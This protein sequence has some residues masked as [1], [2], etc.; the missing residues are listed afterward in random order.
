VIETLSSESS[1][2]T[3]SAPIAYFYCVRNSSEPERADPDEIMRC[4][5]KQLASSK[6]DLPVREPVAKRYKQLKEEAD[7]DGNE[8]PLKLTV[9]ESVELILALLERNPATIIIDALDECDPVRRHELLAALD[10]IIRDSAN[11]VKIFVS[12]RD[13]HDILCRLGNS[14]DIFIRASDNGEDIDHFVRSQVKQS[15]VDKRLLSGKVSTELRERIISVLIE[16]AQG[17]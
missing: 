14:P 5:L 4:I 9:T 11:V 1:T 15:I 2:T 13:D 3:T 8:E 12:S 10:T 7:D 6:S 16:K 17:M